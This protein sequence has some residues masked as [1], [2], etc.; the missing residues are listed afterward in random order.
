MPGQ[1]VTYTMDS[2]S[3]EILNKIPKSKRSE[4]VR[5]GVKLKARTLEGEKPVQKPRQR[6]EIEI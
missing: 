1:N 3:I 6:V 4:F 2:D 5:E